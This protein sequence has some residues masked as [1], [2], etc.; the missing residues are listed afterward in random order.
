MEYRVLGQTNLNVS[1]LCLGSMQFGWTADEVMSHRVLSAAYEAGI[2]FIDTADIYSRWADGNPGGVAEQIIGRWLKQNNIPRDK[3]VLATKVRGNMGEGLDNEGL[4]RKHILQAAENS[5]RRLQTDHIDLYQ[6]HWPDENIPI[7]ETLEA[8][9]ELIKQGKVRTVGAS[10]YPA[11]ELMQALWTADRNGL[12]RYDCL[13]PHYNL[14]HRDEFERELAAVCKTYR[15]GVV[16]YSPL[17][18]G[19]LTGK[20]RRNLVANSARAGGAKR[21]FNERNWVLLDQMDSLAKEKQATISQIALA[22]ILAN[23]L[24][25]SPILGANSVEQLKDNLGALDVQLTPAERIVLDQASAWKEN[26]E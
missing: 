5:L 25:T 21:Y 24:I 8:F 6:A 26:E 13:Q 23:P 17:A 1:P 20:Y 11:W 18:G 4:S 7:E 22:W 10:N 16:P 12:C 2:N 14:V 19:F 3:I 15:L 9:N